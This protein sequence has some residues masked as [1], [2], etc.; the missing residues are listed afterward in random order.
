MR[1]DVFYALIRRL[2][3]HGP[4]GIPKGRT[5]VMA[6]DGKNERFR[7][8]PGDVLQVTDRLQRTIIYQYL[9]FDD[10]GSQR[11]HP[12]ITR[13]RDHSRMLAKSGSSGAEKGVA[14]TMNTYS[15]SI[16]GHLLPVLN[17]HFRQ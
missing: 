6:M 1:D 15:I 4:A 17:L 3:T 2:L 14:M 5:E 12:H 7:M 11:E 13:P 10:N 16:W 8:N 9:D